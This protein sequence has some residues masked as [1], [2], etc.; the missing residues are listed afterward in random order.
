[1]QEAATPGRYEIDDAVKAGTG[2]LQRPPDSGYRGADYDFIT[3][4]TK[5]G[6]GRRAADFLHARHAARPQRSARTANA[7]RAAA[8][9]RGDRVERSEPRSADRPHVVQPADSRRARGVPGR[10]R[11]DADRARPGDGE[12]SVGAARHDSERFRRPAAV[13]HPRQAAPKAAHRGIPRARHRR[14]RRRQRARDRRAGVSQGVP[15]ALRR[16]QRGRWPCATASRSRARWTRAWSRRSSATI[17]PRSA[18]NARTVVNALFEKPWRIVHIAGHGMP[19]DERQARRRRAVERHAFSDPTRSATCATV[20]ELVFVNCC[21]LAQRRCRSAAE[22]YDR[23]EFA[24]GVAGAL[25]A[26]GVR[27]VVAAGWAVDDDAAER[28]RGEFYGSLL[29]GNRFIDA[30][31]EARAAA[32]ERS[33]HVN[34]WAAYQCYGDPDWV[35]RRR[36]PDA[37]QAHAPLGRGLL[38]CGLGDVVE[39]RARADRR[40]DEVSGRRCRRAAQQPG[41]AREAVRTRSGGRAAPSPSSSA[42]RSS[43]RETS[44]AGMHVVRARRRRAGRKGVDE[45]GGAAGQRP[46]PARLGDRRQGGEAS[47]RDEEAREG[48]RSHEQGPSRR[49]ARAR[50]RRAIAAPGDRTRR[51]G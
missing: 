44:R 27:C 51:H 42:R 7:E 30:V 9:A 15:A 31:G 26:I 5:R 35:F 50:G 43:R 33:P 20:P 12:D 17:R 1:M 39:A 29:R 6:E 36:A 8:R 14:R 45:G 46:R 10:Q 25:I 21:H 40:P 16:A 24:S 22:P 38:R 23:A 49:A 48:R 4:E 34:T 11:R 2:P 13:G 18:S 41:T 47:R 3:V 28:V 37:N 32:Y 19:G